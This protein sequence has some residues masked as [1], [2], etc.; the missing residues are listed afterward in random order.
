MLGKETFHESAQ[1]RHPS[2]Q[3]CPYCDDEEVESFFYL[4]I[5]AR[6]ILDSKTDAE[7]SGALIRIV[8]D[9]SGGREQMPTS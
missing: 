2:H 6:F 9:H 3:L 7:G 1:K 8:H 4:F 5:S